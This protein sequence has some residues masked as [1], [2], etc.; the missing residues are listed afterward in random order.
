MA[1]KDELQ[2]LL[3]FGSVLQIRSATNYGPQFFVTGINR[4]QKI[5]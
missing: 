4:Q 1:N 2:R 5:F 3:E